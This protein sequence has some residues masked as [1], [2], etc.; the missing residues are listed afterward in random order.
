MRILCQSRTTLVN[1]DNIIKIF[2]ECLEDAN[3]TKFYEIRARHVDTIAVLGA[4][5]SLEEAKEVL[6][7]IFSCTSPVYSMPEAIKE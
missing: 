6:L 2:I 7:R 5:P 1:F 4:Y 3:H